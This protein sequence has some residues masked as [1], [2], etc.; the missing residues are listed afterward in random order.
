[1]PGGPSGKTTLAGREL[2]ATVRR[3]VVEKGLRHCEAGRRFG[4]DRQTVGKMLS[5]SAPPGYRRTKPV[6]RPKLEGFTGIIDADRD[7]WVPRKRWHTAR[8]SF[9][10]LR[11]G[12]G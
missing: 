4:I 8:G 6:R 12:R 5:C 10:R 1:M 11:D 2:Y 7:T 9:E 3:A